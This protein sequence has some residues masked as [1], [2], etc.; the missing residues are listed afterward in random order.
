ML[1][2]N[3]LEKTPAEAAW[4]L[5]ASKLADWVRTSWQE[6]KN[7]GAK[8][9]EDAMPEDPAALTGLREE[10]FGTVVGIDYIF[11]WWGNVDS[12]GL[13]GQIDVIW[14]LA[15]GDGIVCYKSWIKLAERDFVLPLY[16]EEGAKREANRAAFRDAFATWKKLFEKA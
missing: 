8:Q 2:S 14:K 13:A 3:I 7:A 6:H 4:Q 5:C 10:G 12:E 15:E 11:K 1:V 9:W 16:R